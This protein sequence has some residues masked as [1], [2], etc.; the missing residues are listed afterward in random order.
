VVVGEKLD[1]R[2]QRGPLPLADVLFLA[3]EILEALRAVH[4]RGVVHRGVHPANVLIERSG[5]VERVQLLADGLKGVGGFAYLAPE[6]VRGSRAV[7]ARTDLYAVGMIV[8]RAL[9]GGTPFEGTNSLTQIALKL[10]RDPPSL[11]AATG[12]S[13][14]RELERFVATSLRRDPDARYP[15]ADAAL[16]ALRVIGP[17]R[18]G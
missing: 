10:D 9:T 1:V 14:P 4:A 12:H 17:T 13:W 6:E 18:N 2:L 7:D 15:S 11:E 3:G 8:F 5:L 16:D